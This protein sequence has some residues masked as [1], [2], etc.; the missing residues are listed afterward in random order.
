MVGLQVWDKR[1]KED[2]LFQENPLPEYSELMI[3]DH[4][5]RLFGCLFKPLGPSWWF[6]NG[7]SQP[8]GKSWD[9]RTRIAVLKAFETWADIVLQ[10]QNA[11]PTYGFDRVSGLLV[12]VA[13]VN[14]GCTTMTP[15]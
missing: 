5:G 14:Q 6:G 12:N 3:E 7:G 8:W 11:I 10:T 13:T 9:S 2:P 4:G 15:Y 1:R